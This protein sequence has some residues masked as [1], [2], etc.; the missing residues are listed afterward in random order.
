MFSCRL[1]V[2]LLVTVTLAALVE[3]QY[4]LQHRGTCNPLVNVCQKGDFIDS[5]VADCCS[6]DGFNCDSEK[7]ECW[8]QNFH[9]PI[10]SQCYP[11]K[12]GHYQFACGEYETNSHCVIAIS[13]FGVKEC[14][15]QYWPLVYNPHYEHVTVPLSIQPA[16]TTITQV[17]QPI[18]V[19]TAISATK[20]DPSFTNEFPTYYSFEYSSSSIALMFGTMIV[21]FALCLM[22]TFFCLQHYFYR[23]RSKE[24]CLDNSNSELLFNEHNIEDKIHCETTIEANEGYNIMKKYHSELITAFSLNVLEITEVLFANNFISEDMNQ[25]ARLPIH[26]ARQKASLLVNAVTD[27]VKIGPELFQELKKVLSKTSLY[28]DIKRIVGDIPLGELLN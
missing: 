8:E 28:H 11:C 21:G 16:A 12:R 3:G 25:E 2:I 13:Q 1:E 17:T 10:E 22:V 23:Y 19:A 27:K 5:S 24:Q 4:I 9:K 18:T 15:C 26:T 7:D 6:N 14:R 20:T